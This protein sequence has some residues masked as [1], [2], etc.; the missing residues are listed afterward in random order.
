MVRA[1]LID[2]EQAVR[3]Y[4]QGVVKQYFQND[5]ELLASVAS[6][7]EGVKAIN[8]LKPELVFLDIEM[9]VENGF[10]LFEY[11]GDIDFEVVFITAYQQ[12]A[13]KAFRFAALDYLLKPVDPEQL[14]EA[15]Q[16]FKQKNRHFS[17]LRVNTFLTN[18][19]NDLEINRK[20]IFPSRNG[21]QVIRLS[22]ILFCKA[23][24]SYSTIFTLD[25]GSFTVVSNLKNLEEILP[26]N[27]FVRCHK[28]FIINLNFV[29][30]FDKQKGKAILKTGHE[31]DVAS[32][33]IDEFISALTNN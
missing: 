9:P 22:E 13:I 26:S 8:T 29:K 7:K 17:K 15:I 10:Q 18:Q 3:E 20:I 28:S 4:F 25:D 11:F 2:D 30:S 33:R 19:T 23:E 27:V 14:A 31:V 5:I 24:T 21:Y 1:I 32:R 12:H 6:V 16:R